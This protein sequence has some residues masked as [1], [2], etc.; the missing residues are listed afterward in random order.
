MPIQFD[1]KIRYKHTL[2]YDIQTDLSLKSIV[3]REIL[4]LKNVVKDVRYINRIG[5]G[6][7]NLHL[8]SLSVIYIR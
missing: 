5:R 4:P 2:L 7:M 3:P 1:F 8:L 6:K